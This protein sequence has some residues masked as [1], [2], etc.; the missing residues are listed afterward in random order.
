LPAHRGARAR[1]VDRHALARHVELHDDGC[2][3]VH[4]IG[5]TVR[6]RGSRAISRRTLPAAARLQLA[7]RRLDR[8]AALLGDPAL[9]QPR[10]CAIGRDHRRRAPRCCRRGAARDTSR[11]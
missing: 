6:R 9:E 11:P 1:E 8:V 7:H 4:A 2:S 5:E 10:A 3:V